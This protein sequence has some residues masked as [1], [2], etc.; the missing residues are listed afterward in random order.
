[1]A[2]LGGD[3]DIAA[4][5]NRFDVCA[6]CLKALDMLVDRTDADVA[7]AGI[8]SL[9]SAEAAE[10]RAE[11]IVGRAEFLHKVIRSGT[12][13]DTRCVDF[14]GGFINTPDSCTDGSKYLKSIRNIADHRD[15]AERAFIFGQNRAE[16]DGDSGVFHAAHLDCSM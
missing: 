12:G 3:I 5:R 2:V 16:Y 4:A 1:M 9:G 7:A 11:N 8:G 14:I 10:L 13:N 6:E 15:I